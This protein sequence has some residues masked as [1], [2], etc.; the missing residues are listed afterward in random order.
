MC[1]VA[2][3]NQKPSEGDLVDLWVVRG[4]QG[5]RIPELKCIGG[6]YHFWHGLRQVCTGLLQL[7]PASTATHW[8]PAPPAPGE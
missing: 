8:R 7:T 6:Q 5:F 3:I 2:M 1:W 4:E